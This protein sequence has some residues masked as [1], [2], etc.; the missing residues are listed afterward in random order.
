MAL[1]ECVLPSNGREKERELELQEGEP[2]RARLLEGAGLGGGSRISRRHDEH[3]EE[4]GKGKEVQDPAAGYADGATGELL[5]LL[6]F[7][8]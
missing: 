4:E 8:S 2:E 5:R 1:F 7:L 6:V 3:S